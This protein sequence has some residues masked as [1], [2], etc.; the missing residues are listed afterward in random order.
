VK[1]VSIGMIDLELAIDDCDYATQLNNIVFKTA[2]HPYTCFG[3]IISINSLCN[4]IDS[5]NE[6]CY[7]EYG[8]PFIKNVLFGN[9]Y[10]NILKNVFNRNLILSALGNNYFEAVFANNILASDFR[11]NK[12]TTTTS[13][14]DF[15][16]AANHVKENYNCTIYK[17]KTDGIKLSY[18]DGGVLQIVDVT[19]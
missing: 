11:R 19:A 17:D 8:L 18:M 13:E 4:T 10:N 16:T 15:T 1:N 6:C 5:S 7:N 12:I 2:D 9:Q 14:V 3:N